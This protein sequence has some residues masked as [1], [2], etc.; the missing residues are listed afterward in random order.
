MRCLWPSAAR[1]ALGLLLAIASFAAC[2]QVPERPQRIVSLDLCADQIL[3]ELV[4]RERIAAVTHLAADPAVS[5]I[6]AKAKGMPITHGAAEDVLR[7]DPDLILAGQFGVSATVDLLRRL[8]R[9]VVVVPLASDLDGVRL[10]VRTVAGAVGEPEKG[11]AM[12]ADFD[13]RVAR[14]APPAGSARPTAIVYQVGG[15]VSG[16]GSLAEA[17]LTAAGFRNKAAEYRLTRNG[18]VPLELLVAEPPD[19]LVL[20]SAVD[21]YRTALADNLRHPVLRLLRERHASLELPWQLWLCG[22]PHLAGAIE[23]LAR[24]RLALEARRR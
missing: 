3:V 5:A 22:T 17:A 16:P 19:L 10:A 12:V 14:L 15:S 18:Q 23:R 9:N 24:A 11:E 8:K 4:G 2:A 7:Y 6:P 1:V 13:Q 21:E 20:A